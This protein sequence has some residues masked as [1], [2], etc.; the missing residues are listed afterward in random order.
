MKQKI[1]NYTVIIES[2]K[3]IGTNKACYTALAPTLGIAT[4]ADTI[5]AAKK[6]IQSLIEFHLECLTKEGETIPLETEHPFITTSQVVIPAGANI[7]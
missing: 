1:A 5:E 6:D 7:S 4:E 3:R 2:Q